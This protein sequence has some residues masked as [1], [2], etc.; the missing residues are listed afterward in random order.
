MEKNH[1]LRHSVVVDVFQHTNSLTPL[2]S[3]RNSRPNNLTF[4]TMDAK[5]TIKEYLQSFVGAGRATA[6]QA[7]NAKELFTNNWINTLSDVKHFTAT[8]LENLKIP[9]LLIRDLEEKNIVKQT[10]GLT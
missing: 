3:F 5:T 9:G 2:L 8:Q 7:A 4:S 1:R 10:A 6:Q